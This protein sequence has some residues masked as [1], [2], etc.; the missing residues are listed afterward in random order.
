MACCKCQE[1]G[2]DDPQ[3]TLPDKDYCLFHA[4]AEHKGMTVENFNERVF[5]RI[6][7]VD[8][9][10]EDECNFAG[11][12]FPGKIA[13][14]KFT[15]YNPLPKISFDHCVFNGSVIFNSIIFS[16]SSSFESTIFN[17]LTSF[18]STIFKDW[19][20]FDSTTFGGVTDFHESK[21]KNAAFTKTTLKGKILTFNHISIISE[22][23][24]WDVNLDNFDFLGTDMTNIHFMRC[25]W[26]K[27]KGRYRITAEDYSAPEAIKDFY[28][29]M[30]R[31][32]KQE[33]NEAE[34]SQWHVAEKEVDL[35]LV[36][37]ELKHV[38][39]IH[40]KAIWGLLWLMLQLY[41]I[42]SRFGEHMIRA[43]SVL[44]CVAFAPL[45]V[46]TAAKF[47]ETGFSLAPEWGQIGAVFTDWLRCMPL[48]KTPDLGA[49]VPAWKLGLFGLFQLLIAVQAALFAFA[50]RNRFRR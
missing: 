2:W 28:Q 18:D 49:D 47:Q 43:G 30:K 40:D 29:R 1:Y 8:P 12:I 16:K 42:S 17:D 38:N 21:F 36:A 37:K 13:F 6:R 46:L 15:A 9:E 33:H 41:R 26:P 50:L 34:V 23:H 35:L 25:R 48:I 14:S 32:Y 44:V 22:V 45:A 20:F 39:G 24:F 4:P 31:K 5:E 3:P 27:E 19:V 7:A 11:T 10:R